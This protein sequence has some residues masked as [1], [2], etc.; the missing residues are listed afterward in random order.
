M[1]NTAKGQPVAL[2]GRVPVKVQGTVRKGDKLIPAQ[3]VYGAASTIID[4]NDTNY[5][6]IALEDHQQGSG[7]IECLI[8]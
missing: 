4:K 2:K 5:F 3:N 7:I 8:L 6:A 1:N